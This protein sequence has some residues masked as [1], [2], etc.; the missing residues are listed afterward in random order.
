MAGAQQ[1]SICFLFLFLLV[2]LRSY[3]VPHPASP[4]PASLLAA[5]HPRLSPYSAEDPAASHLPHAMLGLDSMKAPSI[6]PPHH[7]CALREP[8]LAQSRRHPLGTALHAWQL[9]G[10]GWHVGRGPAPEVGADLAW[11]TPHSREGLEGLADGSIS[12]HV[13]SFHFLI[14]LLFPLFS[15]T[16]LSSVCLSL[17][18]PGF[19]LSSLFPLVTFS[20]SPY[21]PACLLLF[22][23]GRSPL[24]GSVHSVPL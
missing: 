7:V 16:P 10:G 8:R 5:S 11:S 14:S 23:L 3:L 17:S 12:C 4:N 1:N 24:P 21:V 9:A 15:L 22:C 6:P 13:A 19:F 18:L 2:V 20:I